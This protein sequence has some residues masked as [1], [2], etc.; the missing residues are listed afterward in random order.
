M[1]GG[2]SIICTFF[3]HRD[4]PNTIKPLLRE[5]VLDLIENQEVNQFVVGNQGNFDTMVRS[6]L[7]ELEHS[8]GIRYEIVLAYFPKQGDPLVNDDHTLLPD[9]IETVPPRFAID[10]R[11][12]WMLDRSDVVVTYVTRSFG[13][14]SKFSEQAKRKNK[15]IIPLSSLVNQN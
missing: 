6:L 14:A 13:G 3:G 5:I 1:G 10:Y 2:E 15:R 8:H 4:A 12:R 11:N 9:G 7:T